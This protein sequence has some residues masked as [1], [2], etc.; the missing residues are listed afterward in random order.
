MGG[1]ASRTPACTGIPE[2]WR[3]NAQLRPG[4]PLAGQLPQSTVCTVPA[5]LQAPP[6]EGA[7]RGAVRLPPCD[8]LPR[9]K[10]GQEVAH[11]RRGDNHPLLQHL[12]EHHGDQGRALPGRQANRHPPLWRY[13]HRQ[14]GGPKLLLDVTSTNRMGVTNQEFINHASL[15]HQPG[16]EEHDPPNDALTSAMRAEERKHVKY[17]AICAAT[18]SILSPFALE[19]MGGHGATIV[20]VLPLLQAVARLGSAGGRARGQTQ[21]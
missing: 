9:G 12:H 20:G 10:P 13:H 6:D 1:L 18:G 21:E 4:I 2:K 11:G 15:G 17:D 8:R 19:T 14:P 16:P 5:W 3:I 7:R